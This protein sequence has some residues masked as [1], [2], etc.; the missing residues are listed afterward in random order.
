MCHG[1]G[2]SSE[3]KGWGSR[4]CMSNPSVGREDAV[5]LACERP[6]AVGACDSNELR[7]GRESIQW[8]RINALTPMAWIDLPSILSSDTLLTCVFLV[9]TTLI[10]LKLLPAQSISERHDATLAA[11]TAVTAY[12]SYQKASKSSTR[13][14]R[15]AFRAGLR[16][17]GNIRRIADEIGYAE[18]LERLGRAIE[19]NAVVSSGIF[20]LAT[21]NKSG[22]NGNE[23]Y[24]R[25]IGGDAYVEAEDH[26]KVR[27][28]LKH[29]VRDWSEEGRKERSQTFGFVLDAL[30]K[31]ES[32][33]GR[34]TKKPVLVP[35]AGLGR[36]AW[37]IS[38]LGSFQV[39]C[40][41]DSYSA[42]F[43][44]PRI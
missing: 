39:C 42:N 24:M 18:K 37:E 10:S 15:T 34:R 16:K 21:T 6:S 40:I 27:E 9:V 38:Q 32:D 33:V 11:S 43:S 8:V 2:N 35:G 44:P 30:R 26:A 3:V 20:R 31:L 36:L 13:N 17:A 5:V 22:L 29:F 41:S 25:W 19:V 4:A 28:A 14:M 12:K 23:K 1:R 7:R